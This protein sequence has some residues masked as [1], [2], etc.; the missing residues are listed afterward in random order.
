MK[1]LFIGLGAIGQRHLRNTRALL[2]NAEF[3]AF[4]STSA[5]HIISQDLT[6]SSDNGLAEKF[7]I[8]TFDNLGNAL[9]Q[10]PFATIVSN[11]SSLHALP[12]LKALQSGSHVFIEKPLSTDIQSIKKLLNEDKKNNHLTSMVG[13]QMRF[14]PLIKKLKILLEKETIGKILSVRAEV[15]EYM[16]WFHRYEDYRKTYAARK[17]LGGGVIMSQIHEIDLM[18][19]LFGMPDTVFASGGKLSTLEI[20][21]EDNV[22]IL[23]TNNGAGIFLHMDFLQKSKKRVGVIYG[24]SG[25]IEYEL[26]KLSL[27]VITENKIDS[28]EWADFER[29]DMFVSELK[30]FFKCA[31]SSIS[32]S[33]NIEEGAKSVFLASKIKESMSSNSLK[34]ISFI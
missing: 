2:P 10:K 18:I 31:T 26:N 27:E 15:C 14:H 19:Y 7:S 3:I 24:E 9:K 8:S 12:A 25:R 16:P 17:D 11:P 13:L 20:D 6:I 28:F 23:M 32:S 34:K 5:D 30:E 29:N 22:D 4:R 1:V 33:I 21:V